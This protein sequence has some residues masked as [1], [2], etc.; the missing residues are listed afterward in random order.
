MI[1]SNQSCKYCLYTKSHPFS[2][3]LNNEMI[4]SGCITHEEKYTLD[5]GKR[6]EILEKEVSNYKREKNSY[7]YDCIV[8]IRGT[9]E[10]FYV[11]EIVKNKLGLNPLVVSYNSQFNSE[12]G[13]RNIDR[14][15][16]VYDVDIL[17][18][19]TNPDIY[20][21]MIRESLVQIN[22]MR[23][24]YIAGETSF[25]VQISIERNI[26]LIIWPYHQ[27]TEQVGMHP[28][29]NARK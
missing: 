11:L 2:L 21:K 7:S 5:W 8:P 14:L 25:P 26:P 4:C 22:N 1:N 16:E 13:I 24:P 19:S 20:K 9:P 29:R 17:I 23:W 28:M 3:E 6:L 27:A 12:V 15:R 10:Y 18:Y